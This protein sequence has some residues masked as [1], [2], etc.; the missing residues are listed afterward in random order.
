MEQID[1][2]FFEH[3]MCMLMMFVI[4]FNKSKMKIATLRVEHKAG[5]GAHPMFTA[6]AFDRRKC[7]GSSINEAYRTILSCDKIKQF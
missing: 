3:K 7:I 2:H 6:S 5:V 1:D 4:G